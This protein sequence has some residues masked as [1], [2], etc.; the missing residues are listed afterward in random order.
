MRPQTLSIPTSQYNNNDTT[1]FIAFLSTSVSPYVSQAQSGPT[2]TMA[3]IEPDPYNSNVRPLLLLGGYLLVAISLTTLVI[4]NVLYRAYKSLPPS[5]TTRHRQS[6]R[7][8]HVQILAALSILSLVVNGY[9]TFRCLSLSY[10][11]WAHERGEVLPTG[12]W[13]RGGEFSAQDERVGLELGRWF[14]DTSPF[15]DSWEIVAEKSR[16]FWWTQ[17]LLLGT[18]VWSVFVGFEGKTSFSVLKGK[19]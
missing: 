4:R 9:Y 7:T 17:Q 3:P 11:V 12:L 8:K 5:Q 15:W 1:V 2:A 16:R 19:C 13:G 14:K 10:R 6:R 18:T